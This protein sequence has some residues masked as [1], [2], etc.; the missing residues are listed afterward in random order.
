M[1]PQ[2]IYERYGWSDLSLFLDALV[3][4]RSHVARITSESK[5]IPRLSIDIFVAQITSESTGILRLSINIFE[6]ASI[7]ALLQIVFEIA[8]FVLRSTLNFD[9]SRL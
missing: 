9:T 3:S 5:G 7:Q 4:L 6:I 8:K 2:T 1:N